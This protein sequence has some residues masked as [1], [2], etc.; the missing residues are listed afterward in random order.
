MRTPRH[1][2]CCDRKNI[3]TT[4]Q[5]VKG[6]ATLPLLAIYVGNNSTESMA[7]PLRRAVLTEV[8]FCRCFTASRF[9]VLPRQP[10]RITV[11][12][13]LFCLTGGA[14]LLKT[15]WPLISWEAQKWILGVQT[16]TPG[17]WESRMPRAIGTWGEDDI[18]ALPREENDTFERK[19]SRLLDLTACRSNSGRRFE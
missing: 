15:I 16:L 4:S 6:R 18:L 14:N 17:G 9:Q 7:L 1:K 3:K 5:S 12:S 8:H 2:Y 10:L 19:G 11:L 13:D